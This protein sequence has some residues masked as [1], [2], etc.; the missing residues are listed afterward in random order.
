[1]LILTKLV[2]GFIMDDIISKIYVIICLLIVIFIIGSC[3]DRF[4]RV[5]TPSNQLSASTLGG[6]NLGQ[7]FARAQDVGVREDNPNDFYAVHSIYTD[8]YSEY[9]AYASPNQSTDQLRELG[10][11]TNAMWNSWY[12]VA[13]PPLY[14]VRTYT[15]EHNMKVANAVANIWRVVIF[16]QVTDLW[17]PIIYSNFGNGKSSVGYDSQQSVYM[18]FFKELTDAVNILKQHRGKSVFAS[19]DLVFGGDVDKW[20]KFANS[21]KLRLSMRIRYVDPKKAKEEAESA[22][23]PNNGGVMESIGDNAELK[24]TAN[25]KNPYSVITNWGE[26]RMSATM[27]S[28]L[29]GYKDPRLPEYFNPAADGD[30][31]GNGSPYEGLR[32]GTPTSQRNASILDSKHSDMNSKYFNLSSGG[33]N[34]PIKIMAVSEVDFLRAEGALIGWDMSGSAKHFYNLGIK[35]SLKARTNASPS[36]IN[37]YINSTNKPIA[38]HDGYGLPPLTDIPVKFMT[39]A[40]QETKLEQIITQKWIA[41]FPNSVEAYAEQRRTGFPR[42]YTRVASLNPN[43]PPNGQLSRLKFPS[44]EYD[45]NTKA[46]KAAIKL[47]RND[48]DKNYTHVWW[49]VK[50]NKVPFVSPSP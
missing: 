24:T 41:L 48:K 29:V 39:G 8:N 34:P 21:L 9:L 33:T 26:A 1:M 16:D 30:V 25:T 36:E 3:T 7:L 22:V 32:N 40:S 28:I 37:N 45:N 11:R 47:L 17:G 35:N 6:N 13:A 44:G 50:K 5:N 20:L 4:N 31:D 14:F 38:P 19:S 49:D 46:V 42:Q 27:E 43:I 2:R 18:S 23:N 15:K 12:G 10:P